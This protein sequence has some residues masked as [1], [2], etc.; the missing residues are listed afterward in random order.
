MSE[1]KYLVGIDLGTSNCAVA[2][3][4]PERGPDAPVLDFPVTQL[5]RPGET[6]ARPL[7][8]SCIYLPSPHELP[9]AA[10]RLPWGEQP[11]WVVGE[12]ARWQGT[13]VPGR[14]VASAKSWLCHPGVDR[15]APILPWGAAADVSKLS[16]VAASARLLAHMAQAWNAAHPEAPLAEQGVVITVP[17]SFDEVARDLTQRAAEEAGYGKIVLL[18]EPQA[19]FY[20][21]IERYPDWRERVSVG[22]L[23]LVV[24]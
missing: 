13:R 6:A 16:P 3:L 21:W 15:L 19:A 20:A 14:L 1:P 7:L 5:Q 4:E 8:P 18:E 24:D 23:I 9:P 2:Y 12:F 10:T 11:E 17:A 22:D